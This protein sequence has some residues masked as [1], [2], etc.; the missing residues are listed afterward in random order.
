MLSGRLC[1]SNQ[2]SEKSFLKNE[3]MRGECKIKQGIVITREQW[4]MLNS[5]LVL[6]IQG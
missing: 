6:C 2:P 4:R 5:F 3:I 1:E